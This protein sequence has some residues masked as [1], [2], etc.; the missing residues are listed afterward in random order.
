MQKSQRNSMQKSQRNSQ[1]KFQSISLLEDLG[2][3]ANKS[4]Y[5]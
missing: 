3:T 4:L 1:Q 2:P 5:N